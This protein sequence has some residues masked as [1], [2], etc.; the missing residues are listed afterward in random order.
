MGWE[1]IEIR[2]E[3]ELVVKYE[4]FELRVL[5]SGIIGV[6]NVPFGDLSVSD[7]PSEDS[8]AAFLFS[9]SIPSLS[10]A[11]GRRRVLV[12]FGGEGKVYLPSVK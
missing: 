7:D 9:N 2:P 6:S 1:R 12:F 4:G 5:R 3:H 10:S 8:V 11:E